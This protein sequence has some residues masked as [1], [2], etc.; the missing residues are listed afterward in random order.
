MWT[1]DIDENL[2]IL[3]ILHDLYQKDQIHEIKRV[4]LQM[5]I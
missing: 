4:R 3:H 2:M 5:K 1:K